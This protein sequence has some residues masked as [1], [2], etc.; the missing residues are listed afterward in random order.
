MRLL[1]T[2]ASGIRAQQDALDILGNNMANLN[3]PGFKANQMDFAEALSTVESAGNV[4]PGGTSGTLSVGSGVLYNATGTD[5]QQGILAP[6][7]R[8]LDLGIDGTGF[9]QVKLPDGTTGY[10]RAGALQVD[11][12]GQLTD[13]Q[14]NI[15]QPNISIPSETTDLAVAANGEI[16]G[17]VKGSTQTLGQI[18]LAGFPNPESLL[19]RGNNIFIPSVSSGT[20]Q[21]GSPGTTSGNQT[22][23]TIHA[24]SLEQSNVN[25]ATSMVDLIQVQRAYQLNANMVSDGDQMWGLANSIR[26]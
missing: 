8:P 19:N 6:T 22:F 7:N 20:P 12:A 1:G 23:G 25:L 2:A 5:F 15:V 4:N 11:G 21:V 9:F 16:T 13:L 3:T 10:T 14:G 17:T 24:Q 18:S 26:R